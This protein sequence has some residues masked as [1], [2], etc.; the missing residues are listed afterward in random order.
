MYPLTAFLLLF[1]AFRTMSYNEYECVAQNRWEPPIPAQIL[2][3]ANPKVLALARFLNVYTPGS[4]DWDRERSLRVTASA[5]GEV[6]NMGWIN[7]QNPVQPYTQSESLMLAKSGFEEPFAGS[8]ATRHGQALEPEARAHYAQQSGEHLARF[9]L[10]VHP[11]YW[12]IGASPDGVGLSSGRLVEIKC[13][14]SRT[15]KEGNSIPCHYLFQ[16]W[17]QNEVCDAEECC[18]LEY[19]VMKRNAEKRVN[20]VVV[21]RSREWFATVLPI[22]QQYIVHMYRLKA[23]AA[24]FRPRWSTAAATATGTSA[25]QSSQI[26][27]YLI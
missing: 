7:F 22:F 9:G 2:A 25:T 18:Y 1:F 8:D 21:N 10:L 12:F 24:L 4:A 5:I 16:M 19:R 11:R 23:L 20:S 14:K 17:A 27:P 6:L 15:V 3:S 13:P 26:K